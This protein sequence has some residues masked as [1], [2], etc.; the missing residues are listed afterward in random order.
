MEDAV[1]VWDEEGS[2]ETAREFIL[3]VNEAVASDPDGFFRDGGCLGFCFFCSG[4]LCDLRS[5]G[6]HRGKGWEGLTCI[7]TLGD[8]RR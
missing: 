7:R 8:Q 3:E 5:V 4:G 6:A 1:E 2:D